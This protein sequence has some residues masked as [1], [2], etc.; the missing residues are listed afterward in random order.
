MRPERIEL[1]AAHVTLGIKPEQAAP[2]AQRLFEE[3]LITH[4]RTDSQ[5]F[6]AEALTEIRACVAGNDL[7]LPPKVRTWKSKESAQGAHE[8]I[9]PTHLEQCHAGA[10]N[11][12]KSLNDLIQ[13][14]HLDPSCSFTACECRILRE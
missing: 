13:R 9:R 6:S 7:P 2:L 8:A 1:P 14:P 5:N 4:H 3:G 11:D 10:D 12:Q